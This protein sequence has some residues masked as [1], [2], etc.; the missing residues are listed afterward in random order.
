M[1]RRFDGRVLFLTG[2]A[3]ASRKR[4][5]GFG[6]AA[7]WR[8]LEE[9]GRGI[10]LTD[11]HDELGEQAAAE[12]REQGHDVLYQHLDVTDE[13][14]WREAVANTVEHFGRLDYLVN[15]AGILDAQSLLG[16]D[17]LV[18]KRTIEISTLGVFLGARAVAQ[19]MARNGGG[20]IVNLSS[21]ASKQGAG[22]Y[23]TAYAFSRA[24]MINFTKSEALQLAPLG[25]RVNAVSPGWVH[26]PF[27][28]YLH[29]NPE[30]HA[31]RM[32]RV[33][34]KRWGQPEE[35]AAGILFLLSDDASYVTGSELLMDGGVSA[36]QYR[37]ENP[38]SSED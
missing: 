25:I 7:A 13:E 18:W 9:G 14:Q 24:G 32:G 29:T 23:G 1:S 26:T 21:M 30:Q 19:A 15:I 31:Y 2:A 20:A 33:P 36:G 3:A 27:T 35:I 17:T 28:D 4:L 38:R 11:V 12:M 34:L 5:M 22:T 37:P 16:V 6:G 8:F 10:V